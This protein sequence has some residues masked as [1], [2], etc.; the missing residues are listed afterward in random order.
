[1]EHGALSTCQLW[2]SMLRR[3]AKEQNVKLASA[4]LSLHRKSLFKSDNQNIVPFEILVIWFALVFFF[5]KESFQD[6]CLKI[7]AFWW[8]LTRFIEGHQSTSKDQSSRY[9]LSNLTKPGKDKPLFW[10]CCKCL[11]AAL[12]LKKIFFC[13]KSRFSEGKKSYDYWA[14]LEFVR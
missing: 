9:R 2:H 12:A 6:A 3:D 13:F 11:D 1:M 7:Y 8:V 10:V 5:E 4:S 14:H